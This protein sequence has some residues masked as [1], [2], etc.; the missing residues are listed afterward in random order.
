MA[1]DGDI[2]FKTFTREQLDSAVTRIDRGRYPINAQNLITEYQRRRAEEQQAMELAEQSRASPSDPKLTAPGSPDVTYQVHFSKLSA[3][4]RA[5]NSFDLLR[6]GEIIISGGALLVKAFRREMLFMGTRVELAFLRADITDVSQVGNFV[7]F[8]IV[9]PR[10]DPETLGF[11]T[12]HEDDA[13]RIVR[14]LPS[15]MSTAGLALAQYQAHLTFLDQ[16]DYVTKA[17]VGANILVFGA[18]GLAGA[19]FFVPNAEILVAWG[20]NVGPLTTDGQWW[21]LVTSMFLHFGV[22]HLA[23]NMWALYVGGRLAER[24]FGSRAFALIY[25]VSGLAGSLASLLWNPAVNSAG[26]SGAIFGV[27]GAMLA[28]FLRKHSAIPATI[29]NEQRWSGI[30]FIGF[31]LMNGFSHVGID[32][33]AHIGGL[34]AGLS[35]GLVLARPVD[36]EAR[37]QVNASSLYVRGGVTAIALIGLLFLGLRFSPASNTAD[38]RFHRDLRQMAESG[39]RAK[40]R[41]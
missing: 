29:I 24:L 15:T 25:F 19:G 21:R 38:Q 8:R 14:A 30:T 20:T 37:A 22:F 28:F 6:R 1:T 23:L 17:L 32:N 27:Y 5:R 16:G 11:W 35:M 2:D 10:L 34:F 36:A 18:A 4:S 9:R 13:K 12:L 31:N 41:Q 3:G 7:S 33:A 39:N 26:A 40:S